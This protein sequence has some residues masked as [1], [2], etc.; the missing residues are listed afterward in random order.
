VYKKITTVTAMKL[1]KEV[2]R[3]YGFTQEQLADFLAVSKGLLAM[4][5]T[6]KRELPTAAL[7]KLNRLH[8]QT[9]NLPAA[10][11]GKKYAALFIKQQT[12]AAT[13]LQNHAGKCTYEAIILQKKLTMLKKN[14]LQA[15]NTLHL[16]AQLRL[17]A[18]EDKATAKRNMLWVNMIEANTYK[19]L[20][21]CGEAELQLL[22]FKIASLE[23][24]AVQAKYTADKITMKH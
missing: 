22:Q 8:Q 17:E 18:P 10:G 5:E 19:R 21:S 11:T 6:G 9:M 14:H 12:A 3:Q 20:T 4:A 24:E 16:V 1:I 13:A 23:K 15:V 7:L 2:R